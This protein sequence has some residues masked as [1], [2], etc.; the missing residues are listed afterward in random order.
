MKD[1]IGSLL[2]STRV[3]NRFL[4]SAPQNHREFPTTLPR[5]GLHEARRSGIPVCCGRV[6]AS[7]AGISDRINS[8]HKGTSPSGHALDS[9]QPT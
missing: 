4:P 7:R 9:V 2:P 8:S 6:P 1:D 3:S 5:S